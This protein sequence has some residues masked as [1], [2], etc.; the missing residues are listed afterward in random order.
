[1]S[2]IS[3]DNPVRHFVILHT[4]LFVENENFPIN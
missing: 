4:S 3:D 2:A 1:M